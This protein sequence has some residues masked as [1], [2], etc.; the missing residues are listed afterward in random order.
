MVEIDPSILVNRI[1]IAGGAQRYPWR[2]VPP[3]PIGGPYPVGF[4]EVETV[5]MAGTKEALL[6]AIV[7]NFPLNRNRTIREIYG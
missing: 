7:S 3:I 2:I 1:N 5:L 4:H 6:S